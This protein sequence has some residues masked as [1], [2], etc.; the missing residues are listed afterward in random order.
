ME[1]QGK[2]AT[3]PAAIVTMDDLQKFMS[4]HSDMRLILRHYDG[5]HFRAVLKN[6]FGGSI[7][8]T[9][10]ADTLYDAVNVL[11]QRADEDFPRGH[12]DR[13]EGE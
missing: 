13:S 12:A 5:A 7:A 1:D 3:M 6:R 8:L 2:S 4:E 11:A 10:H 9:A